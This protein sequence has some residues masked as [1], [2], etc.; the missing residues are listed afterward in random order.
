[1]NWRTARKRDGA[2]RDFITFEYVMLDGSTTVE[3]ARRLIA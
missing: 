2:P 3:H 1:M